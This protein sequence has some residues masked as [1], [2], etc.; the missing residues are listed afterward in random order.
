MTTPTSLSPAVFLDRD[1]T[2]NV[3]KDYLHRIRITSYNVCYTKLLRAAFCVVLFAFFFVTVA[4]RIV[5]LV[6]VTSNPTS[7]MTIASRIDRRAS[8]TPIAA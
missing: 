3:E 4:S 6:G 1:G 2:I 5:G 8:A 7:G